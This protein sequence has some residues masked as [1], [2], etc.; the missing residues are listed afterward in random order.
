MACFSGPPRCAR[1]PAPPPRSWLEPRGQL[2]DVLGRQQVHLL[3]ER[4]RQR[5]GVLVL[6]DLRELDE[7]HRPVGVL[8]EQNPIDNGDQPRSTSDRS[9]GMIAQLKRLPGNSISRISTGPIILLASV[10]LTIIHAQ[11]CA[12]ITQYG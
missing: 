8:A 7:G 4:R 3:A 10:A 2:V 12:V 5:G 9:S 1:T 11:R 6:A